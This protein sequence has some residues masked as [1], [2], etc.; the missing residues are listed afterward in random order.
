[1]CPVCGS[2]SRVYRTKELEDGAIQRDRQCRSCGA[3]FQTVEHL[4]SVDQ[5]A[6]SKS[7]RAW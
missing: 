6:S 3:R 4:I 7:P 2:S 1:M 5:G